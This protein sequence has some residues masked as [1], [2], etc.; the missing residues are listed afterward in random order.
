[1]YRH[2][3][4]D[5][6]IDHRGD[7]RMSLSHLLA[8]AIQA[9]REREFRARSPRLLGLSSGPRHPKEPHT[10]ALPEARAVAPSKPVARPRAA[11]G[12]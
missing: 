9:D 5:M 10:A 6:D 12:G 8:D 7:Q 3:G 1:M 2:Y 11:W 4:T